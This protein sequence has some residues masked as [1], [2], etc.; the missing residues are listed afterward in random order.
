MVQVSWESGQTSPSWLTAGAGVTCASEHVGA[1]VEVLAK[2]S[3]KRVILE[4]PAQVRCLCGFWH[5]PA[6]AQVMVILVTTVCLSHRVL[7]A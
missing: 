6:K 7:H 2:S 3:N 5:L 4:H 1:S